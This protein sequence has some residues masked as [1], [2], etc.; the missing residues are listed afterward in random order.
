M[1]EIDSSEDDG[2]G[3]SS[4]P[5]TVSD[6]DQFLKDNQ[7]LFTLIGVFGTVSVYISNIEY[8][9]PSHET[10][11]GDLAI[12][13][14]LGIALIL[15]SLVIHK[16]L[17]RTVLDEDFIFEIEKVPFLLFGI[18]FFWFIAVI[19]ILLTDYQHA[20]AEVLLLLSAMVGITIPLIILSKL[21]EYGVLKLI[22]VR[23]TL[24]I[25]IY[26]IIITVILFN[27]EKYISDNYISYQGPPNDGESIPQQ[28]YPTIA[29]SLVAFAM[30]TSLGMFL[31][32]SIVLIYDLLK[33][34]YRIGSKQLKEAISERK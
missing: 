34:S 9:Q 29:Q 7:H 3:H 6:F 21:D 32:Y 12:F 24:T 11:V 14:G 26:T 19:S 25:F 30:A 2:S 4:D 27:I 23:K 18:L 8:D 20:G 22:P 28:F 17:S 16:M 31:I 10:P 5:K 33:H 13:T 1:S 15:S